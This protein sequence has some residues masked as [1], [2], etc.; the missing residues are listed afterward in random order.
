V[1]IPRQP[2][3]KIWPRSKKRGHTATWNQGA[4]MHYRRL[5]L[6]LLSLAFLGLIVV[7]FFWPLV[8]AGHW[9]PHGG[10]DLVSFLW[11][12]Y[13]FSAR[14][15]RAGEFPLWNPH[16]YSGAPYVADNQSGVFYPVNLL[17]F[18]LFGEP[19]YA[20][21]EGLVVFHIWLACASTFALLRE[22]GL[23]RAAAVFGGVAFALSD[24]F[25]THI[26]NLNL[27]A[28]V[29][30]MPLLLLLTHRA[31]TSRGRRSVSWTL[32]AGA[33]LATAA[34]AG[35]GQM[36]LLVGLALVGYVVYVQGAICRWQFAG[37]NL[38]VT[39]SDWRGMWK[40]VLGICARAALIVGVGIG[41][42][43]LM[44]LP[45]REM[46]Q[47]TGRSH[48]S[49][50]EATAYSLPPKALVGLLMPSFYGR[51]ATGFWGDWDRVEVGY[52]GVATVT[53][54]AAGIC[55]WAER[56]RIGDALPSGFFLLLVMLGLALALGKYT[57]LYG[58]LYRYI[59]L[60]D[61][62]RVP[63]RLIV[64]ADLGLAALAAYGLDRLLNE[65]G[66]IS[67]WVGLGTLATGAIVLVLGLRAAKAVPPDQVAQATA[68]VITAAALLALSG[69][70]AWLTRRHHWT[71]WLLVGLLAADLIALGST[72]EIE[73]NDPTLGFQHQDV[74]DFLRQ[75]VSLYRIE[76]TAG[77]WQPDAALVHGLYDVDGIFNPLG[78]APYHA[79][80]EVAKGERG[81]TLY[82]LLGA[83]Y[84]L[85]PK[86]QVPGDERL[87]PV[88]KDNPRI[89]VYLN[90]RAL[91]LALLVHEATIVENHTAAWEALFTDFDPTRTVILEESQARHLS[92]IGDRRP[93]LSANRR[94]EA[95]GLEIEGGTI[96]FARYGANEIVLAVEMPTDGW[97][98]LSEVYYPGWQATVD[99]DRAE[100]LRADYTFRAVKLPPGEHVVRMAF[101]PRTWKIGLAVSG[102]T[103]VGLAAWTAWELK[104]CLGKKL[105]GH[106]KQ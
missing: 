79:Y 41:G 10:G 6:D 69:L 51:G 17:A 61:Q 96:E 99:G 43:A 36:L 44:L 50:E 100:V 75:D 97:L 1:I 33:V 53:L 72:L 4:S 56:R 19:S 60:F 54:A 81:A 32:G 80:L 9:I 92:K 98:V 59:P 62:M 26:G 11:P 27:N 63:A 105:L 68:S 30:W 35:H 86:V 12:M 22:L 47:H 103:W 84:V 106:S 25:V 66:R 45:A 48:L 101:T 49:Y 82:N 52:V 90:T 8:F 31:L 38:Q 15:L 87:V 65:P 83:K 55:H 71:A 18:A 40:R 34:L 13:R 94:F 39:S 57:P 20:I 7:A 14:S 104:R 70:L 78:L 74:V 28:T 85:A 77:A 95:E 3:N 37:G 2:I 21:M 91:P 24:L 16:L 93:V 76:T 64:L 67:A 73:P 58:L 23:R 88:Y 102:I 42:A 29:A 5:F 46:A 89:D